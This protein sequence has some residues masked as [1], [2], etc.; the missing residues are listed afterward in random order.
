MATIKL[1]PLTASAK[2]GYCS[3]TF[4]L[5]A[6]GVVGAA[7]SPAPEFL[8]VKPGDFVVIGE[9]SKT[10]R[11]CYADCWVAQ[12]I[13]FVGGARHPK[14]NSLFQVVDID[15]GIVK[16]INADLVIAVLRPMR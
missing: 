9:T 16:T 8:C 11:M 15:T 6:E 2:K 5:L 10:G 4:I 12:V 13:Y 3:S 14:A 7:S 1:T